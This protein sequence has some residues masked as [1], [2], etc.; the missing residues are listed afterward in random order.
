MSTLSVGGA[1]PPEN[2]RPVSRGLNLQRVF[3]GIDSLYLVLEYPHADVYKCWLE[4]AGDLQSVR[5]RQGIPFEDFVIRRGANG[6]ALSVWDGDARLFLTDR[7]NDALEGTAQQGQGMGLMLQLGPI[8]LRRFGELRFT[9]RF[10][11]ELMAQFAIFGVPD[12]HLYQVRVNR[13]D[14]AVDVLGLPVASLVI[15][16]WHDGWVGYARKKHFYTSDRTGEWEGV[17]IGSSEGAVR[18]KVYDK[19]KESLT[20]GKSAF[21]RSVWGVGEHDDI[22][23]ARFEWSTRPYAA[24]FQSLCYLDVLPET[25]VFNLLNYLMT[26]GSLRVPAD[27]DNRSRWPLH[28]LWES[29]SELIADALAQSTERV[30]RDYATKPDLNPSYLRAVA[31]WLAGF[32]ARVGIAE[33]LDGAASLGNALDVLSDADISYLQKA[34]AKWEVL[35]RLAGGRC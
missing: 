32:A 26:W 23:V 11:S 18:F 28:P 20:T 12:P 14:I 21:W 10:K 17:S 33:G 4:R 27:D 29:V 19:V 22:E 3:F 7:V 24:E 13:L 6:Y 25:A 34:A 30:V 8:W 16:E 1:Q 35:M 5:L 15:Q 2:P 31:G 9:D